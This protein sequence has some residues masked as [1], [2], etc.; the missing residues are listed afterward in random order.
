[1]D[2]TECVEYVWRAAG[3]RKASCV[4]RVISFAA[5]SAKASTDQFSK[6]LV[7]QAAALGWSIFCHLQ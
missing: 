6:S 7:R 1:M 4:I 5:G 2:F 3:L